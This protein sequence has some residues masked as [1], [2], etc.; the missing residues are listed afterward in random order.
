MSRRALWRIPAVALTFVAT[1]IAVA[2][3]LFAVLSAWDRPIGVPEAVMVYVA[4][5]VLGVAAAWAVARWKLWRDS[6]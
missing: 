2:V 4:S 5:V 6:D 1:N 3:P